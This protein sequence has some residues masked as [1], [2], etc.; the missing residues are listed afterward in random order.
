MVI[1]DTNELTKRQ[2]SEVKALTDIIMKAVDVL[3]EHEKE[4]DKEF[5]GGI[6]DE[7][8]NKKQ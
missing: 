8:K 6:F 7:E 5:M 1:S 4:T 2:I 3:N